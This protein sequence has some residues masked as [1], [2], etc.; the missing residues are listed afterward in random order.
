VTA[1]S[2]TPLPQ[3]IR[4][5]IAVTPSKILAFSKAPYSQTRYVS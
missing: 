4:L 5:V 2:S 3:D 1:S